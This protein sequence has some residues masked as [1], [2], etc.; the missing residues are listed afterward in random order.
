MKLWLQVLFAQGYLWRDRFPESFEDTQCERWRPNA[1]NLL[2][3]ISLITMGA[4]WIYYGSAIF[5]P[6]VLVTGIACLIG[7]ADFFGL[8]RVVGSRAFWTS[9]SW[10]CGALTVA[11][12]VLLLIL[13]LAWQLSTVINGGSVSLGLAV[14]FIGSAGFSGVLRQYE[15]PCD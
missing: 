9:V 3:A 5:G 4:M 6:T 8:D 12:F 10:A 1:L 11:G 7:A 2:W 15:P 14:V 13:S